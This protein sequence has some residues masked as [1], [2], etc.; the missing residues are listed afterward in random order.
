MIARYAIAITPG[1]TLMDPRPI[2]HRSPRVLEAGLSE[3]RFGFPRLPY[4]AVELTNL[5]HIYRGFTLLDKSFVS[6]NLRNELMDKN[7]TIVHIASHMEFGDSP[8]TTYLLTYGEKLDLDEI[9]ALIV[10]TR[11]R[12]QPLEL[13]T[14]DCCNSARDDGRS[15]EGMAGM[16]IEAGA[17][18]AVATLWPVNDAA[19]SI[20]ME[21][22]YSSLRNN[23]QM[24]KA[25]AMQ[26]AQLSLLRDYRYRHPEYWAPYLV[27]GNWL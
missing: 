5:E 13:L 14:L 22:F 18:S 26:H 20:L 1:L 4:V 25:K 27:I 9:E 3:S 8:Q 11:F 21:D 24:S 10:P 6:S 7:Y 19:A 15:T 23:P 16:A 2:Q 12:N 17:R